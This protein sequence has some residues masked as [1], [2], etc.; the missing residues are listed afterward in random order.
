MKPLS[1]AGSLKL[2]HP[3]SAN[4]ASRLADRGRKRE[5]TVVRIDEARNHCPNRAKAG[6]D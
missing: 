2:E 1:D 4:A 6:Y 5:K 3:P